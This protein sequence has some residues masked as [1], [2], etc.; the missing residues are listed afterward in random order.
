M[1]STE[2]LKARVT[3]EIKRQAQTIASRELLTEAAWLKRLVIREIGRFDVQIPDDLDVRKAGCT[4]RQGRAT[5]DAKGCPKPIYVRLRDEDRLLLEAR[6][7]AR[8]LR[9]AT[10]LSILTR[11]HLRSVLPLPKDELLALK[12]SIAEVAAIGRHINQIAKVANRGGGVPTSLREEF[13]AILKIC[14]ALRDNTKELLK[15]NAASWE[16][17]HAH[18]DV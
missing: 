11:S 10:Y 7:A 2:V 1:N 12:R 4:H 16:T 13:R 15:T 9:P 14:E 5:R 3:P 8:G 18:T 17:G 6:A